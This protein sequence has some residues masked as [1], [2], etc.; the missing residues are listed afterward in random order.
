MDDK[1]LISIEY[2]FSL[3]LILVL[4][5]G[6]LFLVSS[7]ISSTLNIEDTIT[8]RMILDNVVNEI[9]Q[10]NSN[11]IGYS[12]YIKLPSDNGYYEISVSKNKL[13][14]EYGDKKGETLLPLLNMDT[15]TKLISGKS[16]LVSKTDD[17]IV[18]I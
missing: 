12:K 8:H 5:C 4:A 13:T 17:G 11:G 3:F 14:I 10:V 1:G 6:M 15:Q 2:L 7:S 9:S 16:Y 18:I